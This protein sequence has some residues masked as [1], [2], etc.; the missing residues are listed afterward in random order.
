MNE[1]KV[2]TVRDVSFIDDHGKE[3]TGKQ[4]WLCGETV[5]TGWNGWEVIKLWFP[6]GHQ[7]EGVV[8]GLKHDD[9]VYI[10]FNRRGKPQT[11]EVA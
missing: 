10:D 9:L 3:V 1:F 7:L 5:D 4:L 8:S 2:L 6:R 11:I